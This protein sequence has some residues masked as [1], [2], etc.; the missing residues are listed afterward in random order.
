M[1]ERMLRFGPYEM[2]LATGDLRRNGLPVK[3][4][5][6]PLRILQ[7]L[8]ETPGELVTREQLQE[9]LWPSDTFVD[10]ERSLNAAVAKLRQALGDSAE[11]PLYVETV[12]RKGYRFIAPV[13]APQPAA[14][15]TRPLSLRTIGIA[16]AALAVT[17]GVLWYAF[18]PSPA[19]EPGPVAFT[20]PMPEGSTAPPMF[21]APQVAISPDGR[22]LAI[23]AYFDGV[24]VLCLRPV[25]TEATRRL[26]A[27]ERATLPFW[28]P[29]SQEVAFFADGKLKKVAA[30]GGSV[31]TLAD[32]GAPL[33]G[34][35]GRGGTIVFSSVDSLWTVDSGGGA[36]RKLLS[37]TPGRHDERLAWPSMLP[38]GKGF[39]YFAEGGH[40]ISVGSIDGQE[41]RTL[42]TNS[43]RALFA[44]P[45]F[46]L[47]A[48]DG[49]LRAQRWDLRAGRELGPPQTVVQ[50]VNSFAIGQAAFAASENGILLYRS[51]VF[52]TSEIGCYTRDGKRSR[53]A[54]QPGPYLQIA[55]SPD[56]KSAAL[57]ASTNPFEPGG[58]LWVMRLD[59]EVVSRHDFERQTNADPVWSPDS[60]QIAFAA[61]DGVTPGPT[62]L[63]VWTVGETAA[64]RLFTDGKSNKPDD[65]SPDGKNLLFR[66]DDR[67]ARLLPIGGGAPVDAENEDGLKDQMRFSPD[68]KL[69]AYNTANGRPEVVVARMPGMTGRVQVSAAGGM[70]PM[71]TKGGRELVYASID[72]LLM[73]VEI[74]DGA[75]IEASAPRPLFRP[76]T[77][78]VHWSN[79][80]GVSKDGER[81]Y[82]LEPARTNADAW[83][84]QTRWQDFI[85]P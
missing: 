67:R 80:Y 42:F 33:G 3:I 29:D 32:A 63:M 84:V 12:A 6:Q 74:H 52:T 9:R 18:R 17:T 82:V 68:G 21:Y 24:P 26:E 20:L 39:L 5:E 30:A 11:Q 79:Q 45:D 69:V 58:R 51:G 73:A 50:N 22:M 75:S 48:R 76:P 62:D 4:Q 70:Q 23:V 13:E 10:F 56:E 37:P 59:S 71:W 8:V 38:D 53:I 40:T 66:A 77:T 41:P 61:Y 25:G 65:W 43:S 15:P 1:I 60:R 83:H 57:H 81:F 36:R 35:W 78:F 64:R 44:P 31:W 14:A 47:F 27:T 55:I 2:D 28:S 16:A 85:R 72:N 49:V 7:A 54:G 34:S 46:V 19:N